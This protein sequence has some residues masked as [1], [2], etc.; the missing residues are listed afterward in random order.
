MAAMGTYWSEG[1]KGAGCLKQ[2]PFGGSYMDLN[3]ARARGQVVLEKPHSDGPA[4][5]PSQK[6]ELYPTVSSLQSGL[7]LLL[8]GDVQGS[9]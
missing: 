5:R 4:I 9:Y 2:R 8:P 7:C 6:F 1:K 3:T